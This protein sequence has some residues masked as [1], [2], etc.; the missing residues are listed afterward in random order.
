M[1]AGVFPK[2]GSNDRL[3][4]TRQSGATLEMVWRDEQAWSPRWADACNNRLTNVSIHLGPTEKR[5]A[6]YL[7]AN[8]W[9]MRSSIERLHQLTD[10]VTV[11]LEVTSSD[12]TW[13]GLPA[14]HMARHRR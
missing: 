3:R 10:L 12:S 7:A 8:G 6:A 5:V 2:R 9:A 13:F 11:P 14:A 1:V 4:W